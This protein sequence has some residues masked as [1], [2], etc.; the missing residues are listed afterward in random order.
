MDLRNQSGLAM[1][2]QAI[3]MVAVEQQ[4]ELVLQLDRAGTTWPAVPTPYQEA[5]TYNS[6]LTDFILVTPG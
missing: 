5:T 1:A 6:E 4:K 2:K 3:S